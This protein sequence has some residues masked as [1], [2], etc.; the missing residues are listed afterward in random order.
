VPTIAAGDDSVGK[1]IEHH[2]WKRL[3]AAARRRLPH[4]ADSLCASHST[5]VAA[6][7]CGVARLVDAVRA[8]QRGVV[9]VAGSV[10]F[11]ALVVQLLLLCPCACGLRQRRRAH[12]SVK[13]KEKLD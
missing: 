12:R 8:W 7:S 10:T 9:C 1:F 13:E 4:V 6:A 3:S 5:L 11:A 2:G